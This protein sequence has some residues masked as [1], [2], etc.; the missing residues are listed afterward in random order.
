MSKWLATMQNLKS[1]EVTS[2]GR[3]LRSWH[4]FEYAIDNCANIE[5]LI[6]QTMGWR[7]A[8]DLLLRTVQKIPGLK[9]A[10]TTIINIPH[11]QLIANILSRPDCSLED[12]ILMGSVGGVR[13][14]RI[15]MNALQQNTSVVAF[16]NS[17]QSRSF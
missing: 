10:Q 11:L 3:L 12:L 17:G 5:E 6:T 15:I 8:D 4:V 16:D 2:C 13:S 14:S 1:L 7:A 9:R